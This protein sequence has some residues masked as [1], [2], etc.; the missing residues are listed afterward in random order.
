MSSAKCWLGG[1]DWRQ[2]G[3]SMSLY[4]DDMP[5]EWRLAYYNSRFSC[6][7]L[8]RDVWSQTDLATLDLWRS[9]T[10][11]RFRF[12]LE[13][14][15]EPLTAYEQEIV[16]RLADRLGMHGRP[17]HPDVLWFDASV[18][19]RTLG[20]VLRERGTSRATTY[21]VSRDGNIEMLEQVSILIDIL[22]FGVGQ[23]LG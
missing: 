7:W 1:L 22:G 12:L 18:N 23:H 21:L 10:Q 20:A 15:P 13:S 16:N 8:A 17:D 5:E 4:P 14:G 11:E 6:V 9:D 3:W 2:P 19:L